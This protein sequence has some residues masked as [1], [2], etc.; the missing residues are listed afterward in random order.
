[1]KIQSLQIL[2]ALAAWGVVYHHYMQIFY[3]FK[4]ESILG[5]FFSYRGSFGVDLFFVLSGFVMYITATQS[6]VTFVG[7][8]LKRLFRVFPLY[9]FFSFFLLIFS[10]L[11]PNEFKS[12]IYTIES[13]VYSLFFIPNENPSGLGIYPFLTVG[14]TLNYEVA[15]YTILSLCVFLNKRYSIYLCSLIVLILPILLKDIE[16]VVLSVVKSLRMWQFVFGMSIGWGLARL[17]LVEKKARLLG[18]ILL[19]SSLCLL[20][21]LL[22]YGF[23]QKTIAAT[24]LVT[25]FILLNDLFVESNKFVRLFMK[26]GDLSYSTYLCHIIVICIVLH[27]VGNNLNFYSEVVVL[28]VISV[29]IVL[30]S[31]LSYKHIES[32]KVIFKVRDYLI[33]INSSEKL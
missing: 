11:M 16:S 27:F 14:W 4:S 15:F 3:N 23:M 12:S 19:G 22:G 21:G 2:R 5:Y 17:D 10:L 26:L 13:I 32:N 30:V 25:S 33:N 1:M 9:W 20:S 8:F 6:S 24:M 18:L 7:F 28:I 29:L 31:T